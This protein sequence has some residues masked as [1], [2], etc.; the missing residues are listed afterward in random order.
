M[1]TYKINEIYWTIQ[2]EGLQKGR[3]IVLVRFAKCNP[4]L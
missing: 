4:A 3:P 1:K 2:G